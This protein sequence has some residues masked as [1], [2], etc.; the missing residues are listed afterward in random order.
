MEMTMKQ[1]SDLVVLLVIVCII[2]LA[3][4]LTFHSV[5]A[6]GSKFNSYN[7]GFGTNSFSFS[8]STGVTNCV[9]FG[10]LIYVTNANG[11]ISV[12][13]GFNN[14]VKT[15]AVGGTLHNLAYSPITDDIYV[16]TE[17]HY[18]SVI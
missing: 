2:S 8:N 10:G 18:I 5:E 14:I 15:I 7:C 16:T 3:S 11:T 13:D 12:I 1:K 17:A 6:A 4:S 9:S